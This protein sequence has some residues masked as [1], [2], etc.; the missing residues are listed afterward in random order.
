MTM[1]SRCR[2]LYAAAGLLASACLVGAAPSIEITNTPPIGSFDNLAGRVSEAN[3]A[4][5]RVAVFIYVPS[6]GWY[7]K[8]YCNPQLTVIQPNSSWS[9][10]ITTGGA[11]ELAAGDGGGGFHGIRGVWFEFRVWEGLY[12]PTASNVFSR[13]VKPLPHSSIQTVI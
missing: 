2:Q 13:G 6:A 1:V 4:Q 3:P 5:H 11:D 12:T 8:P 10:D 7:S 9:A